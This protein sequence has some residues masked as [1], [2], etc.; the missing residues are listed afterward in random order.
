MSY[1]QKAKDW[2]EK[3]DEADIDTLESTVDRF[4]K[5]LLS[6]HRSANQPLINDLKETLEFLQSQLSDLTSDSAPLPQ[7]QESIKQFSS[8]AAHGKKES[9]LDTAPLVDYSVDEKV[10]L[11][12]K[13]K[14]E[15]I[16]K[17]RSNSAFKRM[18]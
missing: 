5:K 18:L 10:V 2:V 1:L 17:L 7:L 4:K 8:I 13:E 9:N 3:S 12:S 16:R 6:S 14:N 15:A 11:T